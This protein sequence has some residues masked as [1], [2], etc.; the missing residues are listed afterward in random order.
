MPQ[1]PHRLYRADVRGQVVKAKVPV[2]L[3]APVQV[4]AFLHSLGQAK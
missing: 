3:R 1:L 4:A 2:V